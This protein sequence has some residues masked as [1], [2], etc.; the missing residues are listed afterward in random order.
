MRGDRSVRGSQC[1]RD[2][3]R[4]PTERRRS[5]SLGTAAVSAGAPESELTRHLNE[6]N[7]LYAHRSSNPTTPATQSVCGCAE[8]ASLIRAARLANRSPLLFYAE[9][10]TP[11]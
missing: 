5:F 1:G 11:P 3:D 10:T 8:T 2:G 9:K 6:M 7:F 4:G